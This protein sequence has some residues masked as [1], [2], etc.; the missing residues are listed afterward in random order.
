MTTEALAAATRLPPV[1]TRR[2]Y[3]ITLTR[4]ETWQTLSALAHRR[5]GIDD[6]TIGLRTFGRSRFELSLQDA[7]PSPLVEGRVTERDGITVVDLYVNNTLL[8]RLHDR[9]WAALGAAGL[10]GMIGAGVAHWI[11]QGAAL[12]DLA[13]ALYFA[14]PLAF[15]IATGRARR[16]RRALALIQ[17]VHERLE[18]HRAMA[19]DDPF[20]RPALGM[21]ATDPSRSPR[22]S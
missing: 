1:A 8:A 13:P 4:A 21:R 15:A 2:R 6:A 14:F 12:A 10:T 17:A 20:R 9:S 16:R 5:L 3:E 11:S 7:E 18:P 22:S 19:G